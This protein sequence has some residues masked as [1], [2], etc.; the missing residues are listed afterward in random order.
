MSSEIRP[1]DKEALLGGVRGKKVYVDLKTGKTSEKPTVDSVA[2][3]KT[4]W[5]RATTKEEESSPPIFSSPQVREAVKID[6]TEMSIYFPDF[7]LHSDG[8]TFWS[9]G[10]EGMGE[11]RITYPQTYPAQKFLI[12]VIGLDE[13]F[14]KNLKQL[15][16]SCEGITPAG[17]MIL[18]M[19]LF[20]RDK[21]AMR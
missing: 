10:I 11:I 16:W 7:N 20:L 18:A 14:N 13:T 6:T 9:G 17:S 15:V 21:V 5:W 19:R 3:P 2:I 8:E 4:T 12:E 1:A